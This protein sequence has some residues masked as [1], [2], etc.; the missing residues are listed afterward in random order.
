MP[1]VRK[2]LIANRGEI[3]V[4]IIRTC[5]AM[6]VA[7]VAVYSEAD[8]D[9]PHVRL[10]DEAV[11]IGPAP[12]RESYLAVEKLIAAARKSGADA[13]HPGYGFLAEN[14]GFAA[15]VT[16][17]GLTFIGPPA[18]AIATMGDKVAAR[19]RMEQAGVPVVPATA[20]LPPDPAAFADAAQTLGLPVV[21]KAAAGGG[22][23]G[24]RIVRRREEFAEAVAGAARE[25]QAAFGDGR[26]YLERYL[27]RP[28]H[29]EVQVFA[30]T[31]GT[32]VHLG[33]RECSIQRRH[34]KIVEESPSPAVDATLR[35]AMTDAGV[36]AAAAVDYVG[37]GTI[38]FLLDQQGRFY[39]LEMNT[40]L[41]VEHPITEWITGLDLVREQ[42]RVAR[43]EPLG[44]G[45]PEGAAIST[46]GHAIE[47]RLYSEDPA[48]GFLPATGTVHALAEPSGAWV[49][50]DSGI[51]VGSRVGVEYDPLL[52]KIS[53]FG[54]TREEAR[55]RML[56][57]LRE[58][59]LLGVVTN[60]DY[61]IDV[62]AHPAFA[63]G[64]THTEFLAEHFPSWSP[65]A[66]RRADVAAVLAALALSGPASRAADGAAAAAVAP[67]PWEMLGP[68][69]IGR[70]RREHPQDGA[71]RRG[72]A[73][74]L[75]RRPRRRRHG[76][77]GRHHPGARRPARRRD[78][79]GDARRSRRRRDRRPR[80]RH[81][82][83]R[84]RRGDPPLHGRRRRADRRRC[85]RRPHAARHGAHAGQGA[86]RTRHGRTASHRGRAAGDP[87]GDED[88]D[89]RHRGG[90][91][92]GAG[93]ARRG[94]RDDRAGSGARRPRL[95][96]G[97]SAQLPAAQCD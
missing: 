27:E 82:L 62:L 38:E 39:F 34:Q 11:A 47:C 28:R 55:T 45:A 59:V 2:I 64:A 22:G 42:I 24:M 92:D 20:A 46:R 88:G 50:F 97:R 79:A 13:I 48:H 96:V 73:R 23:K 16:E 14:A 85:R 4:R 93:S 63:A 94:R 81:G 61:L 83:D 5:R 29:V 78:V 71:R 36:R 52:A 56:A 15:A 68:W 43:G 54:A 3:A 89:R 31:H 32:V 57:A 6:G 67:S 90:G 75:R 40:R 33:E 41:Q 76:A 35:A 25:A 74:G 10:A 65:S 49:R 37:A 17:A 44:F 87:R 66:G 8:V 53:T 72:G 80:P 58:T 69:R 91:C 77:R 19:A 9:A 51:A 1:A 70:V 7:S 18:A 21:I 30:D 12:A 26:I 86:R 60:R 84:A 95:H